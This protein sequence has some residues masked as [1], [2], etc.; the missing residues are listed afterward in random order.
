MQSFESSVPQSAG[1]D[2]QSVYDLATQEDVNVAQ[3][4]HELRTR[5]TSH[6]LTDR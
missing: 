3:L 2:G 1:I 4:A 5:L 6:N